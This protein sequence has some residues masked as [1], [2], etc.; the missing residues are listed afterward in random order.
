MRHNSPMRSLLSS[1]CKPDRATVES[2][3]L[4]RWSFSKEFLLHGLEVQKKTL[5]RLLIEAE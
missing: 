2:V 5:T 4:H 3:R 1:P